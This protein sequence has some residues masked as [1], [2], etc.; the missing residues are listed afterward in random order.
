MEIERGQN[1]EMLVGKRVEVLGSR[2]TIRYDGPLRHEISPN[3]AHFAEKDHRWLGIEW[4]EVYR[5]RH[6]GTVRDFTYFSTTNGLKSASL[7][8]ASK[9]NLGTSFAAAL[10]HK[11]L[12]LTSESPTKPENT[13]IGTHKVQFCGFD[14]VW[15]HF[16]DLQSIGEMS[17]DGLGVADVGASGELEKLL[18][19]LSALCLEDNL[20]CDWHQIFQL[21]V[22]L[23]ELVGLSIAGNRLNSVP[24]EIDPAI[25]MFPRLKTMVLANMNLKWEDF[26][27]LSPFIPVVEEII[28]SRNPLEDSSDIVIPEGALQHLQLISLVDTGITKFSTLSAFSA[29]P[30]LKKLI[31]NENK[32]KSLGTINGFSSLNS[33]SLESNGIS[34][35]NIINELLQFP[36]IAAVRIHHNPVSD[37]GDKKWFRSLI[38]SMLGKLITLNGGD[39]SAEERRLTE[40]TFVR[41]VFDD[42]FAQRKA[43]PEFYEWEEF[44]QYAQPRY[45]RI[46]ELVK[47]H[48][49]PCPPRKE[50]GP[51][52]V[53]RTGELIKLRVVVGTGPTKGRFLVKKYP[54]NSL[55]VN[56][57]VMLALDLKLNKERVIVKLRQG[58]E[59]YQTLDEDLKDLFSYGIKAGD[60]ILVE[61]I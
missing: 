10:A 17:L 38:V 9:V 55:I 19:K 53:I 29:L 13:Q 24:K 51:K 7:V 47:K 54:D 3:E 45:P 60:E 21:G 15:E 5:G 41:R 28:L 36:S 46:D 48:G 2:G 32:I 8:K 33:L 58:E 31:L 44:L 52:K 23:R 26:I 11:Y 16:A 14:K 37:Y 49:N 30:S 18:P 34:S 25:Q 61:E 39:I 43:D 59:S 20:L 12:R 56:F 22:E 6:N 42:F 50:A 4:D 27:R 40:R 57:R 35:A 1:E